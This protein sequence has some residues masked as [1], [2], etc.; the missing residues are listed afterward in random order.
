[1]S[2]IKRKMSIVNAG[3]QFSKPALAAG[4][5]QPSY[6][7]ITSEISAKNIAVQS[8]KSKI[9]S[10]VMAIKCHASAKFN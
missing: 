6:Y 7:L 8:R 9:F 5:S 1:M 2:F 4:F 10:R 3:S